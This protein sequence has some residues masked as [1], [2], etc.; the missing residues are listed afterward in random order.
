MKGDISSFWDVDRLSADW[1]QGSGELATGNA[2]QTAI[3]IS[4]F[5][6][7]VARNDDDVDGNERRGWWGDA[8]ADKDIGSRLWLLRRR[9]LTANVAQKAEEYALEGLNWLLADGVV[10]ALRVATQ[11][12]YPKRLNMIIHYRQSGA[13]DDN[14][15]R[16]FWV[17]EQ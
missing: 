14:D 12:V 6:D 13:S 5:T 17:W 2:L 4:L 10:S 15:M 1:Q 3:I 16:F 9:K 11:I 8:G 7:R